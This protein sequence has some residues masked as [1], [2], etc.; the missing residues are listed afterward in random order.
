MEATRRRQMLFAQAQVPFAREHI[1]VAGVFEE[2]WQGGNI[3]VCQLSLRRR[4][5]GSIDSLRYPS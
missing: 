4:R 1:V 3:E 5:G 2:L